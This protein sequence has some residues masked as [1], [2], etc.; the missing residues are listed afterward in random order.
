MSVP[1]NYKKNLQITVA[2]TG[3]TMKRDNVT[4]IKWK[5]LDNSIWNKLRAFSKHNFENFNLLLQ[6]EQTEQTV[7]SKKSKTS[8]QYSDKFVNEYYVESFLRFIFG[9]LDFRKEFIEDNRK[10]VSEIQRESGKLIDWECN[11]AQLAVEIFARK[12][13][14]NAL[15]KLIETRFGDKYAVCILNGDTTTD[16]KCATYAKNFIA[17]N[18][19]KRVVFNEISKKEAEECLTSFVK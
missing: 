16:L 6:T 5:R 8:K 15:K 3:G 17:Q 18:P 11:G 12:K 14:H 19:N 1:F 7:Q 9:N 4:K 10:I 13:S 2:R